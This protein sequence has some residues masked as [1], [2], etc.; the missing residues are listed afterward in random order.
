MHKR[1][2][3]LIA[4][5]LAAIATLLVHF[6]PAVRHSEVVGLLHFPAILLAV[7]LSGGSHSPS[8][9]A[10]WSAFITYAALYCV[11][12]VV[13]YALV[14]ELVLLRGAL[15]QL[16]RVAD[17]LGSAEDDPRVHLGH[18][19]KALAQ[20]EARRRTHWVLQDLDGLDPAQDPESLARVA[21]RRYGQHRVVVRALRR[22]HSNLAQLWGSDRASAAMSRLMDYASGPAGAPA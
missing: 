4:L 7:A 9:S 8:A 2:V 18:L 11:L 14:L 21:I 10:G 3:T 12:F 22:M 17:V 20:L 19:G 15:R 16:D 1:N 6:V 5:V 13:S